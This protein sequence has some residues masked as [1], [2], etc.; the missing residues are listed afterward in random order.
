MQDLMLG[1]HTCYDNSCNTRLNQD[2]E[3]QT[4][5]NTKLILIK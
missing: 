5:A 4:K 2:A 3:V 1:S